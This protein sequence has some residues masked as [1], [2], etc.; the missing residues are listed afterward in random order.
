VKDQHLISVDELRAAGALDVPA[1]WRKSLGGGRVER[2]QRHL[3]SDLLEDDDPAPRI[4]SQR[5][6][7]RTEIFPQRTF[8]DCRHGGQTNSVSA[9]VSGRPIANGTLSAFSYLWPRRFAPREDKSRAN[10]TS[11]EATARRSM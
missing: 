3:F 9:I 10:P 11:R 4:R 6:T 8:R 1:A 7:T 5:R 2:V